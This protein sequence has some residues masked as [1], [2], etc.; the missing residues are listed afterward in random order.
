MTDGAV[1][2]IRELT[3]H[4]RSSDEHFELYVPQLT[5]GRAEMV[6]VTGPSGCGKSTLLDVLAMAAPVASV[7]HFEFSPGEGERFDAGALLEKAD[8]DALAAIRRL[9]IGYVLQT[10]GLLPFLDVK[11]NIG[12]LRTRKAAAKLPN[13]T[14]LAAALGIERHLRKRPSELSAGERQRVAIGRALANRP[15]AIIADEP[16]AALDP[17][18]SDV[19][20]GLL[21]REV[22]HLGVSCVVAT[23]DWSRVERMGL[24]R[25]Q[26]YFEDTGRVGWTRSVMHD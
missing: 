16:T 13:I 5:I 12:L 3:I 26:H 24:R 9:H 21:V 2:A 20:M 22:S 25:I 7:A 17:I 8:F 18:T 11:R 19:I 6:A 10:G 14:K 23:H 15:A 1:F 4:K